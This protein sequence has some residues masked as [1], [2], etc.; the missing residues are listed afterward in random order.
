MEQF[1]GNISCWNLTNYVITSIANLSRRTVTLICIISDNYYLQTLRMVK[2]KRPNV[3]LTIFQSFASSRKRGRVFTN[4]HHASWKLVFQTRYYPSLGSYWCFPCVCTPLS[5]VGPTSH[6][7]FSMSG[8]ET[9]KHFKMLVNPNQKDLFI[10]AQQCLIWTGL[11]QVIFNYL[12]ILPRFSC[13]RTKDILILWIIII[14]IMLHCTLLANFWCKV[15]TW[16]VQCVLLCKPCSTGL[17]GNSE[18]IRWT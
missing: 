11:L 5:L 18:W 15:I 17:I 16:S 14:I 4:S 2:F 9:C 6:E 7:V 10:G 1:W 12:S 8:R 13:Y 3:L